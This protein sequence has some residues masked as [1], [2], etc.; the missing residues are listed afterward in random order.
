[1]VASLDI[2]IAGFWVGHSC[3][4][5]LP[6]NDSQDAGREHEVDTFSEPDDDGDD[7]ND[8]DDRC[9]S[10]SSDDDR[11]LPPILQNSMEELPDDAGWDI[12]SDPDS[13]M[14][15]AETP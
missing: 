2:D 12:F 1:M 13:E 9:P 4:A 10:G 8:N 3:A 6:P 7:N 5:A 15:R 11:A 14:V